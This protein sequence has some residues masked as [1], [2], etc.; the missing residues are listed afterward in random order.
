MMKIGNLTR[1]SIYNLLGQGL[2]MLVGL[3]T[4]PRLVHALGVDRFGILT[5]TW[6]VMGY[7][8][9][10]DL[11][12][13]RA[14]TQLVAERSGTGNDKAL[15]DIIRTALIMMLGLGLVGGVC[16]GA[17]SPL[18]VGRVLR[19][20][21]ALHREVLYA[22]G[23]MAFS[24]PA[25][26]LL[27]GLRGLL[28]AR[29]H[30][31][32]INLLRL[33]MGVFT[34]LGPWLVSFKTTHLFWVVLSLEVMRYAA[35]GAHYW[36]CRRVVPEMTMP[37]SFQSNHWKVLLKFG[38]WMTVSNII[39][40]L[41]VNMDRFFIGAFLSVGAI[42]Y[43]ATPFDMVTKLLVI[44]GAVVSVLFPMFGAL[45]RANPFE[46]IRLYRKGMRTIFLVLAPILL[47]L[48][49]GAHWLLLHWLGPTFAQRGSAIMQI[50]CLGVLANSLAA[51]PFAFIQ[52]AARPDLTAKFHLIEG[53]LYII[54]LMSL[55][56][57][58]G[59]LGVAWAWTLRVALD[60][61]LLEVAARRIQSRLT[62]FSNS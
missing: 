6:A 11:G 44:S 61:I 29:Q 13:G 40:P 24:V 8:S 27:A 10:F 26:T 28:E 59:I 46:A 50:L 45:H 36:M 34:F 7:F 31:L 42:A 30:F 47:A 15:P 54:L 5:L 56:S 33:A 38:G 21:P 3:I 1:N 53:P 48:G 57:R 4:I 12:L 58:L 2:P 39:S 52:G 20:S 37:A 14:L 32:E 60:L 16:L 62:V 25:V 41:M 51:V 23:L 9:L 35:L 18:V 19:M 17:A 43:Y 22:F 49:L 55:G